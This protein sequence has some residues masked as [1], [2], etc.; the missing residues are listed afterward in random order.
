MKTLNQAIAALKQIADADDQINSFG[1][2]SI[3]EF[4][5]SGVTNY[6]AMWVDY[7][8]QYIQNNNL[9]YVFRIYLADRLMKGKKNEQEVFSDMLQVCTDIVAQMSSNIYGWKLDTSNIVFTPFSDPKFDDEDAGYYFDLII[10]QAFTYDRCSIPFNSSITNPG[11]VDVVRIVDQDGNL[12]AT[13]PIGNTYTVL[14]VNNIYGGNASTV[15]TNS[16]VQP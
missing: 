16:I 4:A 1:C 8:P 12:I 7:E 15:F 2:G 5:T 14:V 6:P 10:K 3:Q 11:S 13:V 9:F